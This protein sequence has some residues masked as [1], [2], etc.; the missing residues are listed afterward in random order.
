MLSI[1]LDIE[2]SEFE[3]ENATLKGDYLWQVVEIVIGG[4]PTVLGFGFVCFCMSLCGIL[5]EVSVLTNLL[6]PMRH[7][8]DH[9]EVEV[10]IQLHGNVYL[11]AGMIL[12]NSFRPASWMASLFQHEFCCQHFTS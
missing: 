4:V 6:G 10:G 8:V 1:G 9:G 3:A 12:R 2:L 7:Q 5:L 11:F